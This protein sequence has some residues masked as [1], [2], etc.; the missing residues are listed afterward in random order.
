MKD[1]AE[2]YEFAIGRRQ[3]SPQAH[4]KRNVTVIALRRY[5]LPAGR[6]GL[7]VKVGYGR[8]RAAVLNAA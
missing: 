6:G 3:D 1:E 2:N 8:Y 5:S 7:L 4:R